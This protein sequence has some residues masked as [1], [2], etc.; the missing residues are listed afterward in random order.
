M[1]QKVLITL[2]Y[3]KIIAM[4]TERASTPLGKD[5]CAQLTPSSDPDEI[6]RSQQETTD[7][8]ARLFQKGS[9][10]IIWA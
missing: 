2:E 8:V 10:S 4:L 1:N 6:R 9:I 7:A 5:L 3:H